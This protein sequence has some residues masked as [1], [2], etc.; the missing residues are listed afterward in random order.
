LQVVCYQLWENLGKEAEGTQRTEGAQITLTD[1]AAAGNV[2][3]ALTQ[4]YE[5]TLAA[6]LADPEATGV[7]ERQLRTWFDDEL[8]TEAGTRGLVRQGVGDTGGLPNQV[9]KALQR[10]FLVRGE[11]RGGD[12]WIELVHDRLVEPIRASNAAWFPANLSALQRQ[13]ALWEEQGRS[14]DLLLRDAVLAEAGAWAASHPEEL[15]AGEQ[16]FLAACREAQ[17]A[18]EFERAALKLERRAARRMRILAVMAGVVAILAIAASIWAMNNAKLAQAQLDRQAGLALLQEAYKL[19]KQE[20]APGAI[21]KLQAAQVTKTDL[22]IDV[23]AEIADVRRQVATRLVQDGEAS[24]KSGNFAAAEAKFKGALA[25][26]PPPD[27]PVYVY[28][29]AGEFLMGSSESEAPLDEQPQHSVSLDGYWIQRTE[30]TNAQYGRCVEAGGCESPDDGNMRYRNPQFAKQP[31][32]GV[33]WDQAKAYAAWAGGRLPTEAEWE[34][35]CRGGL[36]IPEDP[37]VGWRIAPIPG[38]SRI[39]PATS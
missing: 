14:S 32:T 23:E 26:E 9:V 1:L 17:D 33:T 13:A 24:A 39:Q 21:E 25:L 2:D 10:R 30:V 8:I 27:T 35:T 12:T 38:A 18:L 6:A 36:E 4:F 31:V 28:V 37:V 20:D 11:A 29:P 7:S 16:E 5:E 3:R 15:S 22:G 34:K 19:K